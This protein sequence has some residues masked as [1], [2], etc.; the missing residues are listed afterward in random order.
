MLEESMGLF[1]Y[2]VSDTNQYVKTCRL[3]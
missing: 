2:S 3:C 1:F